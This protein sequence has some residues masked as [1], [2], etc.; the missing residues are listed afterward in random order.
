VVMKISQTA[1]KYREDR[2]F[3][4]EDLQAGGEPPGSEAAPAP[5]PSPQSQ[6]FCPNCGK[7]VSGTDFCTNCGAP[8]A[9]E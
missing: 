7:P 9:R 3:H 2:R 6:S 5:P 1:L 8:L 4:A